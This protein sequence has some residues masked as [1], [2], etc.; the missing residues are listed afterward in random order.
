MDKTNFGNLLKEI[1]T[2]KK[3]NRDEL[4]KGICSPIYIYNIERGKHYPSAFVIEGIAKK[5]DEDI[6]QLFALSEHIEPYNVLSVKR[7]LKKSYEKNDFETIRTTINKFKNS[8]D[9]QSN[10][11]KQLFLW[12]LG[13]TY[14][15]IDNDIDVAKKYY[16]NAL[17]LTKPGFTFEELVESFLTN[18]ELLIVN[19]ILAILLIEKNFVSAKT[20]Y[21]M[22][23]DNYKKFH[24]IN[25]SLQYINVIYNLSYSLIELKEYSNSIVLLNEAISISVNRGY[26][27]YLYKLYFLK[28]KSHFMLKDENEANSCF[29]K[30][31]VL[32]EISLE[33]A[34]LIEYY[35]LTL[36]EKYSFVFNHEIA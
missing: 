7:M 11:E 23:S 20:K 22:L 6:I 32:A 3:L 16:K 30:Y 8:P 19:S 34:Q 14:I 13:L 35:K 33:D 2:R 18:Q 26:L 10:S 25:H 17:N 36:K 5:L 9:F 31:I 28:G 27:K 15:S 1:R 24:I 4:A 29:S 21:T 12:Y